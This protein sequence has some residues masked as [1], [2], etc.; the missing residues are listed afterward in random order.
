MKNSCDRCGSCCVQIREIVDITEEDVQRW[1]TQRRFDILQYCD[2]W[3]KG[4]VKE[5]PEKVLSHLMSGINMEMWFDSYTKDELDLCPFLK[6]D[7]GKPQFKCMIHD[8]KPE[9]CMDYLCKI[10]SL[11]IVKKPFKE[12]FKEYQRRKSQLANRTA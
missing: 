4:C 6:K 7:Y 11:D 12:N 10:K 9:V 8:T 1:I 5:K 2:G 3:D